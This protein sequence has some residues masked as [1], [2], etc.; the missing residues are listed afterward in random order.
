MFP[1]TLKC[2]ALG[3]ILYL[4]LSRLKYRTV[5]RGRC[6]DRVCSLEGVSEQREPVCWL[7]A[8]G[9]RLGCEPRQSDLI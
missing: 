5:L 1:K 7:V 4:K 9:G 2:Q 3:K 8:G 6:Y